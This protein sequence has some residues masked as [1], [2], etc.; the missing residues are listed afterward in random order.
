M[1]KWMTALL[2]ISVAGCNSSDTSQ[3]FSTVDSNATGSPDSVP[4]RLYLDSFRK[5]TTVRVA[6][7]SPGP[8]INSHDTTYS[9]RH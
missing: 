1:P 9:N 2:L 8:T 3:N 6:L 5:D 4:R 7:D